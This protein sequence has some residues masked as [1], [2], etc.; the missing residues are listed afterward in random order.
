[1]KKV[2]IDYKVVLFKPATNWGKSMQLI[3]IDGVSIH[4]IHIDIVDKMYKKM[5]GRS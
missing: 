3:S 5:K 2:L 4:E 1:M